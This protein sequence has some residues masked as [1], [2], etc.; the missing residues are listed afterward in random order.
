MSKREPLAHLLMALRDLVAWLQGKRVPGVIIGGV[1]ASIL[2][3]PRVTHDVDAL[4]LLDEENW[5]DF[6]ISGKKFRFVPRLTDALT[7]ARKSRV[8][9]VRHKPSGID[10]DITFGSLPFEKKA[11]RQV[12]WV[13]VKGIRLPLPTPEDL[14]IMKA[15][16]HRARDL[17]DIESILD[18]HSKLNLQRIRRWVG[19]FS[20]A[21][22]I[23][24][25]L[26]D[27]ERILA[28]RRKK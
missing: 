27:L 8:L 22:N 9:L 1:A 25:I 5:E 14:I 28:R 10:V 6:L 7:F 21:I 4:V 17:A 15:I 26:D 13:N 16:A 18:T 12:V 23:P 11:I 19:E 24:E 3:R 2:G 20:T